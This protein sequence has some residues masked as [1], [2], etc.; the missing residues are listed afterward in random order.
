M[1]ST[2]AWIPH[3]YL[4]KQPFSRP[5]FAGATKKGDDPEMAVQKAG[6]QLWP[7]DGFLGSTSDATQTVFC[8]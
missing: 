2:Q 8:P 6:C 7:L 3:G 1:D 5:V 4:R